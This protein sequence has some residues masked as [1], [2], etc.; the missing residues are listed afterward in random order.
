[1]A[2]T[3]VEKAAGRMFREAARL[4]LGSP[5]APGGPSAAECPAVVSVWRHVCPA[6]EGRTRP[7]QL[8]REEWLNPE[9]WVTWGG[10]AFADNP[11]N[12]T[13]WKAMWQY[14][15]EDL[16]RRGIVAEYVT[17]QPGRFSFTWVHGACRKCEMAVRSRDGI[18]AERVKKM[19]QRGP[20][21]EKPVRFRFPEVCAP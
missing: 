14:E 12:V 17:I 15:A 8:H 10:S 18:F 13:G 7:V 4:Q 20:G 9:I 6:Q 21:V 5:A 3:A 2:L 16:M 19:V 1:V 11:L